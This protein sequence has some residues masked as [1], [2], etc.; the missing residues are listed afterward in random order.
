MTRLALRPFWS[1]YRKTLREHGVTHKD[2]LRLAHLSFYEGAH[3]AVLLLDGMIKDGN[4]GQVLKMIQS[5]AR[6]VER[7]RPRRRT[8]RH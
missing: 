6:Q 5:H 4:A 8:V 2:D 3:T 7:R 1:L